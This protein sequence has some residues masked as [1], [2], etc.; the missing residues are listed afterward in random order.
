M[1]RYLRALARLR[2]DD[3]A[4]VKLESWV[5]HDLR[6]VVQNQVGGTRG[7][8]HRRRDVPRPRPPRAARV[9]DLHG[10]AADA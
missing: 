8:R 10:Y 1:L 4:Q 5:V 6:R 2:G 3:P 7:Q 9:Y